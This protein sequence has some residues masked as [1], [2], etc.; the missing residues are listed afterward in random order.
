MDPIVHHLEHLVRAR[1]TDL[2]PPPTRRAPRAALSHMARTSP[3]LAP[4]PDS[5]S[6]HIKLLYIVYLL[7]KD[8][9]HLI[10]FGDR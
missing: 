5:F 1:S 10:F 7:T 2:V 6:S 9:W 4:H 3:R 8:I